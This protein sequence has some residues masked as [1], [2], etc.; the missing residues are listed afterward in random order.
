MPDPQAASLMA[1]IDT[2]AYH[3]M[4]WS[5][6]RKEKWVHGPYIACRDVIELKPTCSMFFVFLFW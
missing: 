3:N 5:H 2:P 1:L 6:G 4:S